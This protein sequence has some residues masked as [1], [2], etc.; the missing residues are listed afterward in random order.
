MFRPR[1]R[2]S[3]VSAQ[4]GSPPHFSRP[5]LY[6]LDYDQSPDDLPQKLWRNALKGETDVFISR[7]EID[8]RKAIQALA[9]V[10][11]A[12]INSFPTLTAL[13]LP[14]RA[15]ALLWTIHILLQQTYQKPD[16]ENPIHHRNHDARLLFQQLAKLDLDPWYI[17]S[18]AQT[19]PDTLPTGIEFPPGQLI[20]GQMY[21]QHPFKSKSHCYYPA[22]HYFSLLFEEREQA[23]LTLLG[24]LGAAK[25]VIEAIHNEHSSGET[26]KQVFE[27]ANR[28][29]RLTG[30]IDT[31]RYPWLAYEPVWQSV[32]NERL[33]R[34]MSST[35]FE[36]DIDVM[37]LLRTQIQATAQL[38]P[39][40]DSMMLPAN[41]EEALLMQV[42][43][44]RKVQVKF[45]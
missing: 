1:N 33:N 7:A 17:H 45:G 43:Q 20:P 13:S 16:L 27:Y 5:L 36:F 28:P 21:R 4:P 41:Y 38:I 14:G 29:Q 40:L 22:T 32:V 30:S 9:F 35:Q 3:S 19:T 42:I 25:I 8:L 24:D 10:G 44:P 6:V 11:N 23:L 37:G 18:V 2:R 12:S 26:H 39:E 34:G 31:Q 15:T